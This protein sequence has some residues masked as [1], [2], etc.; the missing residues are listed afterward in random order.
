MDGALGS[1]R[2]TAWR[3]K[4]EPEAV[5][6]FIA[7]MQELYSKPI[8]GETDVVDFMQ[9]PIGGKSGFIRSSRGEEDGT[10]TFQQMFVVGA[11]RTVVMA[12]YVVPLR[13]A[14]TPKH[15]EE[16]RTVVEMIVTATLT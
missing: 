5:K 11:G 9:G 7:R 15:G 2:V 8:K 4:D 14:G 12:N 6:K 10:Q 16:S 3:L 1:V 13:S